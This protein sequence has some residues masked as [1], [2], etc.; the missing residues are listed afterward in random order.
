MAKTIRCAD[1]GPECDFEALADTEEELLELVAD[2]A[3]RAHGID[4]IDADMEAQVRSA[5]REV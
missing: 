5:I 3:R 2:H 1:V 4:E